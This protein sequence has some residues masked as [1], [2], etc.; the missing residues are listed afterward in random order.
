MIKLVI[1]GGDSFTYGAEL[2]DDHEA[3]LPRPSEVS[4]ANLVA[5]KLDTKH[6]NTSESGRSNDF[7]VRQVINTIYE[8]LQH[9]YNSDEIF[10]QIMWTFN[11]RTEICVDFDIERRDSPWLPID[12]HMIMDESKSDWFKELDPKTTIH[13]KEIRDVMHERWEKNKRLDVVN[14]ASEYYKLA[15][16]TQHTY[17]TLKHI[18]MLQDFLTVRNIKYMFTYVNEHVM[19]GLVGYES[20]YTK[21][22][23]NFI[24]FNEWY[25]FPGIYD[26]EFVGFDDW[27]K[28]NGYSYATS[29]PLEQAHKDAA[30]LLYEKARQII[31]GGVGPLP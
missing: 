21:V 1:S 12:S 15:S 3:G 20:K 9:D 16:H 27:A 6:I 13:W 7:I 31:T 24:K 18:L 5:N 14:Y 19:Y 25:K 29:H 17:N 30:E 4:W 10:V 11:S 2:A 8:A 23:H 26:K 28:A 22:L